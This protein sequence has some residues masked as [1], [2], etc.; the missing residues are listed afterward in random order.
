MNLVE[1]L[2]VASSEEK[3]E[4]FLRQKGVLKTFDCCPFCKAKNIGKVRR[5]LFKCY[6]CKKEWSV[7]KDSILED[8]KIPFSKFILA[9]KLFI[10]EVPVN[11]AHKE[12]D[13]AYN[14]TH[15]IYTKIR[16][17]IYKFVSKDG[18]LLSG[19]LEMDES[20]FGG[21]R[22]G[23][24]GR[25]AKD[26][27]PVFGILERNGK[28]KVE[29]VKDVSGETLLRETIKKVKRGSL[30]YTDKFKSYD[31]L[32]MYGFRHE[33]IDKSV[34]FSNGKVYINGIEGFWSYAKERLLKFHGVSRDSFIYYLKELE[35]RYNFRDNIEDSLY[36][37]LGGIN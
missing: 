4:E 19:E 36:A 22:K 32:V 8:L 34:R 9:V 29:V 7:R 17:C 18:E 6:S 20:Y 26:K 21:R 10:L 28:V 23:N 5:N 27:I 37:C 14:T 24:R 2:Q 15:K 25:G 13:L 1:L 31:S 16:E 3:A 30:I 12:L 35:F 11:K 33:R